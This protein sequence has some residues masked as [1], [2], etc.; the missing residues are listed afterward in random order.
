M[1]KSFGKN[2][3]RFSSSLV[4]V[5][6]VAS[7][8]FAQ[9]AAEEESGEPIL[10]TGS[11][12]ARP[13]LTSPVP[14]TVVDSEQLQLDA[15]QNISDTLNELPQTALGSTRTNTNFSTSGTGIA[16]VNLRGLGSSRT[17]TLVNG[18]RFISGFPGDSAVDLN[19]IPT[20]F[21]ERV[22][23][24]T[25]GSSAVYGS[26]AI[27]GVVNFILKDNFEGVVLRAQS[28]I[29]QRGDNP[30]YYVS[31]TAGTNFGAD[32]RGNLMINLSYDK[33]GGLRSKE[34]GLSQQDCAGLV[35]GPASYSSYAEQG[36]FQLVG[37]NAAGTA[38]GPKALLGGNSLFTFNPDN[39]VVNGFPVGYGFNRNGERFISTPVERYL[40]TAVG[41]YELTDSIT[42]FAEV[43]YAKVN[44]RS[45]L[46]PF[47]LDAGDI[48]DLNLADPGMPITNPFI[49]ASVLAAIT[50]ANSDA[51]TTN[52]VSGIQF[53]R[54]QNDVFDRSNV[55]KRDTWRVAAG[56]KGDLGEKFSWEASYVYGHLND[57]NGSE[58]ID[59]RRYRNALNA[60]RVS[61]GNVV[62]VNIVCADAAA[63]AE[64]CIPINLF[65]Y[66][67]ADP[68]AAAYVKSVVPKSENITN[69]Q[70]VLSGSVS[71]SLFALPAGDVGLAVGAE[72]RKERSVD[73]LDVLTNTGGN[74]GNV[75][76]DTVGQFSVWEAFGEL[77]V[78]LLSEKPFFEYLGLI[79]A[80]RYSDYSTIGTTFS[81]NAGAEWSPMSGL[82][83]R[84]VYAE[85]NR[86]PNISELF[87]APS[88]TFASVTD[89]CDGVNA[90]SALNGFGAACR[91]VPAIAAAIAAN[92]TFQY[93]LADLQGINGFVGG[94]VNLQEETAKTYTVGAVWQPTFLSG[95]LLTVDYFNIKVDGAINTLGRSYSISQCLITSLPVYCNNVTRDA[96]T[97]FVTQVD[98]QLINVAGLQTSGVDVGVRY[99]TGLGLAAD[100]RISLSVNYTY[101][102]SDKSQGD[103]EDDVTDFAGTFGSP[104]HRINSRIGYTVDKMTLSWQTN[105]R[106][107]GEWIKD[108]VNAN[109][110]IA[111]LNNLEDYMTHDMQV[112][113]AVG[114]NRD[115]DVFFGVDNVLDTDPEYLPGSPF[116]TPTGLETAA[117]YDV[118]GRRFYAGA[119]VRF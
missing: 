67:T 20:D 48:Y 118:F 109:A 28:H 58:D 103:P 76:P 84:G 119:V 21:I 89:P 17:L 97:G 53:R 110:Q 40:A 2:A 80:A 45:R 93:T 114:E 96:G 71:G 46:E 112:R 43:T 36:R 49:P 29:T 90:T 13:E 59:N 87:S 102:I 31:A 62:G 60:I 16:T 41:N 47:P 94:N 104:R 25:G 61:P 74:S 113:F 65:G 3:L 26:D 106:S 79:G 92:G 75:I 52:N 15:A 64:G 1:K 73:D 14:V 116:G 101:L 32:D 38:L 66:R 68:R 86:A 91:A 88:E 57:Y 115:F 99:A 12:I 11:R 6:L 117:Q 24:V 4:A 34:R 111:A 8:A 19:N 56:F 98:G 82:R 105:F 39:S 5:A 30:R 70:H 27:S 77:N 51:D 9:E 85:A 81:W 78:P 54:R 55:V 42:A 72:Y 95:A 107:G 63:R 7:P 44:S 23:I 100:D 108:Y 18:R 37:P 69:E 22:E 50:A 10:V 33:D 35:C 83:I